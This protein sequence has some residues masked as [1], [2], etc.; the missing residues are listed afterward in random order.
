V[1]ASPIFL[2]RSDVDWIRE[3]I[4]V[5]FVL[6]LLAVLAWTSKAKTGSRKGTGV[7]LALMDRLVLTPT[8]SLHLVRADARTFLLSVHSAGVV[9]LSELPLPIETE[10]SGVENYL[11]KEVKGDTKG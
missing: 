1:F 10:V 8:T 2:W 9:L 5:G 11:A 3:L 7:R 4:A 6:A